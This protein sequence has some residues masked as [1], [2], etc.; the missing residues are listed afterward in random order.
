MPAIQESNSLDLLILNQYGM[1]IQGGTHAIENPASAEK[2]AHLFFCV[3][4]S[5]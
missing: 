1:I 2:C 5:Q 4:S 3:K